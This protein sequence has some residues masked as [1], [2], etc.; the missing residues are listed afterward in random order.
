MK[1]RNRVVELKRVRAK[2]LVPNPKNWRRHPQVQANALRGLLNEVG[3]ADALLA[4]ELPDGRLQ[5]VDGHLRADVM[6]NEEVP[7]LVLD[8]DEAEADKLLLTLDPLA[9]MA[10]ADGERLGALLNSVRT[11]DPGIQV[12]L[13]ELRT[14]EALLLENPNDLA[15]PDPQIDKAEELRRKWGTQSGQLWQAKRHRLICGDCC[16]P[17]IVRRL[18]EADQKFRMIWCDPSYGVDFGHKNELLNRTDNG[19]RIQKP[20]A[21]DKLGSQAVA[22]MF[23]DALKQA[24]AFAVKGAACYATVP[25]GDLLP[26]FIAA[27]NDSGFSFKHLLVWVKNHFV[28]GMADY[29]QRHEPVLYG[30]REDGPH[31]FIADRC[32]ASVFE[33]DK[34][35]TS[36]LHPTTKPVPLI[37]R[38]IANSSRPGEIVYDPFCGSGSTI[39]AAAQLRRVGLGCELDPAYLA[40]ELERLAALGLR[41]EL[42][43]QS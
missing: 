10:S 39:V 35:H 25:S 1:I 2:D 41:P 5:L 6:P 4:R 3:I 18:F 30:W 42:R 12:L 37:A 34:P 21:N 38:M 20:I 16:D 31:F 7:V 19:N 11:D 43:S 26:F 24:L 27:F 13:E 23:R 22:A 28:I 29:Q 8:L 33:V 40:V 32:Q 9:A 14:Q 36:D 17:E 15:D